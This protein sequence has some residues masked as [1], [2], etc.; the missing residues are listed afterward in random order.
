[1]GKGPLTSIN[2]CPYVRTILFWAPIRWLTVWGPRKLNVVTETVGW[3]GVYWLLTII[4]V[5]TVED[6]NGLIVFTV[7]WFM[8]L[9]I[10]LGVFL[11]THDVR[12]NLPFPPDF[13][14]EK[15]ASFFNLLGEYISKAHTQ[16]CPQVE[17]RDDH[18][19]RDGAMRDALDILRKL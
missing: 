16:V 11:G 12:L 10:R 8:G 14:I 3:M 19:K 6:F 9:V 1:M 7:I 15:G 2:L 4:P 18:S 17:L 5:K 13:V